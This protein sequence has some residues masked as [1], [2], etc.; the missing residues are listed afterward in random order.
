MI[1]LTRSLEFVLPMMRG[2]DVVTV[3]RRLRALGFHDVG[4]PDGLY[5]PATER[6]VRDFQRARGLKV[7]GVAG[8]IVCQSLFEDTERVENVAD[9]LLMQVKRLAEV[10]RRFDGSIEWAL[11]KDGIAVDGQAPEHS[12]GEPKT[13]TRVWNEFGASIRRW[14]HDFAVPAELI[15]ATICT[16][17]GGDP[18][19]RR[20]EH[21]FTSEASTPHRISIGLMQ[22][23]ISTARETLRLDPIDGEWLLTADNSIRAG[24]A[25]IARQ[26]FNTLFDPPVVAC[27]YNAGGVYHDP[28]P[29]NRWRMRQFPKGKSEHA[30]RFVK[31]FNDCFRVL[32]HV[33]SSGEV[34]DLPQVSM[35]SLMRQ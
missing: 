18:G 35:W 12:G 29:E 34:G 20:E 25:Y 9:T 27:A 15:V 33:S 8:P 13:V 26:S 1:G 30:D 31:W 3:Q 11:T 24:T 5:G 2:P 10:H 32:E 23:M 4:Q 19:A 6:A 16:E 28:S 21:G 17:S 22:T 7:D 14:S